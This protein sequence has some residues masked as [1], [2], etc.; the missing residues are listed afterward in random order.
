MFSIEQKR[1]AGIAWVRPGLLLVAEN[2]DVA[3]YDT[4]VRARRFAFPSTRL[5]FMLPLMSLSADGR[6]L[7]IHRVL[8]DLEP[9]LIGLTA[10]GKPIPAPVCIVPKVHAFSGYKCPFAFA[11]DSPR[12]YQAEV[13]QWRQHE[14]IELP[15]FRVLRSFPGTVPSSSAEALSA[16]FVVWLD[17][18][19]AWL[20]EVA[21]GTLHSTLTHTQT[22]DRAVFS[23][24]GRLLA[25][26]ARATVRVWDPESGQ[27]VRRFKG[28][29]GNV[30]AVAFHPSG[31]F[32]AVGC[33]DETVRFWEVASGRELAQFAWDAGRAASLA[34]SPDGL[35]VAAQTDRAIVVWDVDV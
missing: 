15:S 11:P 7:A 3:F 28:Q 35:T 12:A 34:F 16:R 26:M 5:P 9:T 13:G 22:V 20:Y 6:W 33:P 10:W 4:V 1:A 27:C 19:N 2:P 24:D 29:R 8:W 23:R 17:K 25:T 30:R 18:K 31:R 32:L 14:V 21:S